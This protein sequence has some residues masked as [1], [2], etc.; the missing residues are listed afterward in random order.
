MKDELKEAEFVTAAFT[1]TI[2]AYE[3]A[4]VLLGTANGE[5][6]AYNP[7]EANWLDFGN[8]RQVMAG[9]IGHIIVRNGQ[10]VVADSTGAVARYPIPS[11]K[12]FPPEDPDLA[13][14]LNASATIT[15]GSEEKLKAPITALVMD[16]LNV[17]G[18]LGTAEGNIHY[19]NF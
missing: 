10:V 7:K 11:G 1:N 3:S 6:A 9:A 8:L 16:E 19:V 12:V 13:M 18:I 17:E 4:I 5:I 2:I 14:V 15:A